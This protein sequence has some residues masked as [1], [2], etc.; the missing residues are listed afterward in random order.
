MDDV[1]KT[2]K[3]LINFIQEIDKSLDSES[4]L[5]IALFAA[6][7]IRNSKPIYINGKHGDLNPE[8]ELWEGVRNKV[9]SQKFEKNNFI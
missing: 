6:F 2:T 1:E 5:E 9:A 7:E 4:I 3:K 8:W